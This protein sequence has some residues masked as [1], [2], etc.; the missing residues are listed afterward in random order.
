MPTT[1][2][3]LPG[4][5]IADRRWCRK[6]SPAHKHRIQH[7]KSAAKGVAEAVSNGAAQEEEDVS[8]AQDVIAGATWA[9][10]TIAQV[11]DGIEDVNEPLWIQQRTFANDGSG[12]TT[13]LVLIRPDSLAL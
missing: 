1:P 6:H 12:P 11:E 4:S 10:D 2:M 8:T 7:A 3:L 13:R 5:P 9:V